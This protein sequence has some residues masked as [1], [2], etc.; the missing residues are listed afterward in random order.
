MRSRRARRASSG[1]VGSSGTS[2]TT[3]AL[4]RRDAAAR[5]RPPV[6]RA[7]RS[8]VGVAPAR[9]APRAPRGCPTSGGGGGALR[10]EEARGSARLTMTPSIGA[11][12]AASA[13]DQ[14]VGLAHEPR[15][16]GGRPARAPCARCASSAPTAATRSAEGVGERL[17]GAHELADLAHEPDAGEALEAAQHGAEH[18]PAPAASRPRAGCSSGP[19]GWRTRASRG[20][21]AAAG[22]RRGS[23]PRAAPAACRRRAGRSRPPRRAGRRSRPPCTR[24]SRRASRRGSGRAGCRARAAPARVSWRGPTHELVEGALHVEQHGVECARPPPDRRAARGAGARR[25]CRARARPS[26]AAPGRR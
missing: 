7:S 3:G 26:G 12:C 5:A 14:D 22:A 19:S 18:E 17:D 16:R 11:R 21:P 15:L 9:V 4:A 1:A 8:Q 2:A 23:R 20:A 24:R 13:R 25:A 10:A 6:A